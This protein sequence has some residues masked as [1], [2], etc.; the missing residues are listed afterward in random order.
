MQE[1]F[2]LIFEADGSIDG[3]PDFDPLK[4]DFHILSS[5]I[6]SNM[7]IIDSK[8]TSAKQWRLTLL[9]KKAGRLVVPAISFGKDASPPSMITVSSNAGG[10]GNQGQ[11]DIFVEA[12]VSPKTA[13]VQSEMM[14]TIRL[15]RSR[16]TTNE[17]LSSPELT[18]GRAI[19]EKL[20]EDKRYRTSIGGKPFDV[21]ERAYAIYPQSSGVLSFAPVYFQAQTSRGGAF[22]FN[23]FGP[24]PQTI[25]RQSEAVQLDIKPIPPSFRGGH[26][27]PAKNV[28]ITEEW[29]KN[30]TSLIADE[31][32][33][34]TLIMTANGLTASQ[35]PKLS[36]Q[37]I[38]S[39]KEYADKPVL[40]DEK[41]HSGVTG[42]R[43]E[44]NAIIPTRAGEYV[45]P[46][47]A[48]PWWN[49]QT[50]SMEY[51]VLPERRVKVIAP[52][53]EA[54]TDLLA[55]PK[56]DS[57]IKSGDEM[58]TTED[59]AAISATD[60]AATADSP[61][62]RW[63]TLMLAITWLLTIGYIIKIRRQ[64]KRAQRQIIK[65]NEDTTPL[66]RACYNN[67]PQQAKAA[68]L[69][70]AKARYS[71][72]A[73]ASLGDIEKYTG[74]EL[75]GQISA[76]SRQLY[77]REQAAW[78]GVA[79]WQAFKQEEKKSVKKSKDRQ[80]GELEPLFRL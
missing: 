42:V 53:L 45:L 67:D 34:R 78:D 66:K 30:P 24:K 1:S 35:L 73:I 23:P 9:A 40:T 79:F 16:A 57:V 72:A 7:R 44:K 74:D 3:E 52:A 41:T 48:L 56:A 60:N 71:A 50:D 69:V 38:D 13:Y 76:L 70:W 65:A 8:I 51:A 5:N 75:A 63:L 47:I 25:I 37:S 59:A 18:Q 43:E 20:G 46:E 10:Q 36:A 80:P 26:W 62:W 32:V 2:Q 19:I 77:A 22:I 39:F 31:P 61:L 33:T 14:Y 49:T 55:L 6:S 68:L 11:Q 28:Q 64:D 15:Y 58:A 27:L 4:R 54:N 12:A 17:S 21:Y 29:S